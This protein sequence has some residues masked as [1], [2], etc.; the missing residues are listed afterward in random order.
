MLTLNIKHVDDPKLSMIDEIRIDQ[1]PLTKRWR[2]IPLYKITNKESYLFW[3][4]GY[5]GKD[6]L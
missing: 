4:I 5:D 2:F 3:Q 6:N 1:K